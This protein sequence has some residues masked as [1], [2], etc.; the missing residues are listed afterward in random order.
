MLSVTLAVFGQSRIKVSGRVLDM[1]Q[2]VPLPAVSVLSTGGT[3]TITDSSGHYTIYAYETDSIW[4]SY[5][6]KPTPKFPVLTIRNTQSFEISLHVN[7]TELK[8]VFVKSPGYKLDS[9]RNREE[10][11]KAFNFKKPGIGINLNPGGAV[12]LDLDQFI[13]MFQF[14]RNKR[15]LLFQERLL[16][17]EQE[18]FIQHRFNKTLVKSITNLQGA[19]LD[20]FMRR[21]Q[22]DLFFTQISTDYEF[23]LYIKLSYEKYIRLKKALSELRKEEN[24]P[25]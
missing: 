23:R 21:Y 19:E 11:A 25:V 8:E 13:R 24:E 17:E 16:R 7:V 18:R 22:P 10:Y 2:S 1:S 9:I 20:T 6:D 4:F 5:L 14:S 12:G 15:M 3:G